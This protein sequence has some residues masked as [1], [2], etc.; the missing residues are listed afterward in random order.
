[1][2][3]CLHFQPITI[4]TRVHQM[5][6]VPSTIIIS[7]CGCCIFFPSKKTRISL[8]SRIDACS[9]WN[10]AGRPLLVRVSATVQLTPNA[11]ICVMG[12]S[13]PETKCI[14]VHQSILS[15][16]ITYVRFALHFIGWLVYRSIELA[17][18]CT[19]VQRSKHTGSHAADEWCVHASL[20]LLI[21]TIYSD[22]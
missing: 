16:Q 15:Q 10:N 1:M 18:F 17:S 22:E 14:H 7:D 2:R 19:C 9:R 3:T 4:A 21:L 8:L 6:N 11:V 12:R 5:P 13:L 20:H